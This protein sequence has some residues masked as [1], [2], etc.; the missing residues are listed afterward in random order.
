MD[1][2]MNSPVVDA[3]D[4]SDPLDAE[5]SGV[6]AINDL[7]IN[8][9]D[10]SDA[11]GRPKRKAQ[12][13]ED[14]QFFFNT[15]TPIFD[16]LSPLH[17]LGLNPVVKL[18]APTGHF[19]GLGSMVN[20]VAGLKQQIN[21]QQTALL[22]IAQ[23]IGETSTPAPPSPAPPRAQPPVKTPAPAKASAKAKP[24]PPAPPVKPKSSS[25]PSAPSPSSFAH[26][27]K[28]PARPSLVVAIAADKAH[29]APTAVHKA[30]Q[31]IVVHLNAALS[32]SSHPV[33][34]SAAR[35]TQKNNLVVVAGPDTTAHH[36]TS[37]SRFISDTLASFLSASQSPLPLLARENCRWS[38][39]LINGLPTGCSLTRGPYTAAECHQ[40]LSA[41]NPIYRS[42]RLTQAASWVRAPSTYGPGSASS[43]VIVFEDPSGES[44]RSLIE[45]RTLYA[46]GHAG[47]LR[48]WK[49]KPRASATPVPAS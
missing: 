21:A 14:F 28:S 8:H 31:D 37:A 35:W 29:N 41:D 25:P 40:A 4:L 46:F 44:M 13:A 48:R 45:G 39:L 7:L 27:A 30:P 5:A 15:P 36:L 34:L 43:L 19:A 23:R 26:A 10:P 20:Q 38:R 2:H 11:D 47:E 16:G 32:A 3:F 12:F 33:T 18:G 17:W 49:Q 6:M 22:K 9:L 24:A 42:L 1:S